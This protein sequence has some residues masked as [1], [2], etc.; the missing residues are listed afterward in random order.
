MR[1][2]NKTY[3]IVLCISQK[4]LPL[5]TLKDKSVFRQPSSHKRFRIAWLLL[6]VYIP[7]LIA[8]TLHHHGEAENAVPTMHCQDCEHHVH[9]DGHLLAFQNTT[10]DCVLCQLQNTLYLLPTIVPLATFFVF[11]HIIRNAVCARC[12]LRAN[13]VKSTRA[14]PYLIVYN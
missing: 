6:L 14:P 2:R 9:H 1:N 8:V 11:C 10:H 13:D 12:L 7:M 5:F 4:I 3:V